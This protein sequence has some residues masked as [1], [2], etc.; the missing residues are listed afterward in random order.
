MSKKIITR[1][2]ELVAIVETE[3]IDL[4]VFWKKLKQKKS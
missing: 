1:E 2:K 3:E 4:A